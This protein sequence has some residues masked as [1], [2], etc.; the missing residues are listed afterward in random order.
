MTIR[1]TDSAQKKIM[2]TAEIEAARRGWAEPTGLF[3]RIGVSAGICASSQYSLEWTT[4]IEKG[5]VWIAING[6]KI[7]A[8]NKDWL[9]LENIT[10][11][12]VVLGLTDAGFKIENLNSQS[13]CG[14]E[15]FHVK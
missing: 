1:I 10:I 13:L 8:K 5:D 7:L 3:L 11:D 15:L 2:E 14:C 6:I 4:E 12:Y 9:F